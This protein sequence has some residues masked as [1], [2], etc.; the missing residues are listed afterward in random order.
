[1]EDIFIATRRA[2]QDGL[3]KS[4]IARVLG[5]MA[6]AALDPASEM[7]AD[8]GPH[9]ATLAERMVGESE[10]EEYECPECGESVSDYVPSLGGMC[11]IRPCGCEVTLEDAIDAGFADDPW[12]QTEED[13]E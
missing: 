5:F 13:D 6:T 7:K 1:M 9:T 8:D 3:S 4:D 11:R 12:E 2:N 10:A